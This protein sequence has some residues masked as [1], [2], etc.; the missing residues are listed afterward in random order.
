MTER[1][2]AII[3]ALE[4]CK[5]G[6]IRLHLDES[7]GG[8]SNRVQLRRPKM[9]ELRQ[10]REDEWAIAAEIRAYTDP[11]QDAV[12]AFLKDHD[13]DGT[14]TELAKLSTEDLRTYRDLQRERG[15]KGTLFSEEQRAPWALDVIETLT[16]PPK[17]LEE[18]D[19]PPW[20]VT[21]DFAAFLL[22]HWMTVPT[23]RGSP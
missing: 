7:D 5:D 11:L 6:T 3:D 1:P 2:S 21:A 9:R 8:G 16:S 23:R 4:L 20:A 19:L 18:D 17:R 13:C 12:D 14:I 22:E 15:Q 10:F